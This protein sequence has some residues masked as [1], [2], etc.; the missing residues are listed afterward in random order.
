M[1]PYKIKKKC[2]LSRSCLVDTRRMLLF[3]AEQLFLPAGEIWLMHKADTQCSVE[4]K[5]EA[6]GQK[7]FFMFKFFL[8]CHKI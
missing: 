4:G 8:S 3:M 2:Y 7:R 5:E 6:K 1:T